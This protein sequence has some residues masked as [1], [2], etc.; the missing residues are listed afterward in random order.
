M[1]LLQISGLKTYFHLDEGTLK[2]VDG[3]DLAIDESQTLGIIGES[4]CGK[5]VTAKSILQL[6]HPGKIISGKIEY[7]FEDGRSENIATLDR[8]GN[9]MRSMRGR[10]IAMIFQEPMTSLS[11][12][13]TIGNQISEMIRLHA[14]DDKSQ[15]KDMTVEMIQRVGI[16]N[17]EQ[18]YG[19]YPHQ[20][21]G[22]MRQRAMIAM[23]LSCTPR[24]LIADEP[25]TALDVTIQAQILD[26]IIQLQS[27]E[28]MAIMYITHDLGVIAEIAQNVCVMYLGKIVEQA[29]TMDIFDSPMHPYTQ[30]LLNSMPK[31]RNNSEERLNPIKGT[32][33]VPLNPPRRCGFYSRCDYAINGKCDSTVPALTKQGD[34]HWVRCFLSSEEIENE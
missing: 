21:S 9:A 7:F 4:G 23:A 33:P 8:K 19:E 20:L 2:A 11:P 15:A 3:V 1:A 13:H 22:G 30:G 14:T 6:I 32:V 27:E 24:L 31:A 16:A 25:T 34:G 29:A 12:V 10:E 28:Q 5:S 26:L 17:P 18:R